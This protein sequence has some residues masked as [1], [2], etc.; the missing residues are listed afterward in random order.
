MGIFRSLK[1]SQEPQVV[2]GLNQFLKFSTR[3]AEADVF[4]EFIG[5]CVASNRYP[6]GYWKYLRRNR[7]YPNYNTLR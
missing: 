1:L 5:N 7:I 2:R 6:R 4:L 3:L